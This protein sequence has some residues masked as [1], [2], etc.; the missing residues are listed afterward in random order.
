MKTLGFDFGLFTT[1]GT[2][3]KN[4][5]PDVNLSKVLPDINLA[6]F[7]LP[8]SSDAVTGTG[9]FDVTYQEVFNWFVNAGTPPETIQ[10]V[11]VNTWLSEARLVGKTQAYKELIAGW[12]AQARTA[13]LKK[14]GLGIGIILAGYLAYK[15][16]RKK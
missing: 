10:E 8:Q 11:W 16:I 1:I 4:L 6:K 2:Q 15:V 5:F 9:D 3:L 14:A 7:L 12:Q 13:L